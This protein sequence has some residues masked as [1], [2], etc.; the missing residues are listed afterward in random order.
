MIKINVKDDCGNAPKKLVLRDFNI[1]FAKG[2]AA[3]L[4]ENVTDDIEWRV[5]GERSIR[6]IDAFSNAVH[7][8][9]SELPSELTIETIITH[10]TD[11]AVD[12]VLRFPSGEMYAF[13]D[14][15]RFN[16]FSKKAKIKRITS[17]VINITESEESHG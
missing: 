13:C 4:I 5:V 6:G 15:Y 2:D 16:N 12:G 17:Y 7:E 9:A 3:F 11:C 14:V 8:M 1:A 10:G